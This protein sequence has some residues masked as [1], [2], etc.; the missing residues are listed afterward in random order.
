MES[1]GDRVLK[2]LAQREEAL[3]AKVAGARQQAA[4]IIA[5]AEARARQILADANTRAGV[6]A[7]EYRLRSEAEEAA[8]R[9]ASQQT[10]RTAAENARSAAESRI[11][12]AVRHIVDRV[13]PRGT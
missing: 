10:A 5:E 3:A 6:L 4:G 8:I 7:E 13:I 12:V 1:T 9:E 2:E 11:P